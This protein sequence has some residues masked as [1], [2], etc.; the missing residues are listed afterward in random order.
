MFIEDIT[1]ELEKALSYKLNYGG[2]YVVP[3]THIEKILRL[4]EESK[5]KGSE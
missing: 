4:L 2:M 1:K 3:A 5:T